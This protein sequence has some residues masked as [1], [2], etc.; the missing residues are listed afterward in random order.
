MSVEDLALS[1]YKSQ[2]FSN[3][4]YLFTY[5]YSHSVIIIVIIII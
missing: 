3:G 1:H 2:G 4:D 5:I